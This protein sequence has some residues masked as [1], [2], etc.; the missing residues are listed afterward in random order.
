MKRLY[1]IL[2]LFLLPLVIAIYLLPVDQRQKFIQLKE[3]CS[4]HGIWFYDR[5][6]QN[7]APADVVFF[8]SSHTINSIMDDRI[9][10]QLN[11]PSIHVVNFGYC[12]YGM[13]IY[14]ALLKEV[15]KSKKPQILYLE[16]R[17]DE[18]RYSHPV[19]PY[20]ADAN[21]IFLSTP[22]FNRDLV[23]DY[24]DSFLYRLKLLKVQ[25]FRNDSIVPY[26]GGDFGFM[27]S[28]DTASK[29]FMEKVKLEQQKPKAGLSHFGRFF[30]MAYPRFYL[31]KLSELCRENNILLRFLYIPQYGS[32]EKGPLEMM[33]YMKYGEVLIPPREIFEDPDNWG[34]ENHMN[35]AGAG[36]LSDWVAGQVREERDRVHEIRQAVR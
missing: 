3:D 6:H 7:P 36:K 24:F 19:F 28:A 29:A 32:R 35:R 13:N 16:V 34:D 17:E 20:I 23:R 33:T 15:L 8:G 18:D 30:Y 14:Y 10:K 22:F 5:V 26:Q 1:L 12:R 4:G 25:Y 11:E 31:K 21:D 27:G 2:L 9:E